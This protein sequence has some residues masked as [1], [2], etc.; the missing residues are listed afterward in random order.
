MKIIAARELGIR[1][2][3]SNCKMAGYKSEEFRA[4]VFEN[5]MVLP[6]IEMPPNLLFDFGNMRL[7]GSTGLGALMEISIIT[8]LVKGQIGV[9]DIESHIE[10]VFVV[11]HLSSQFAH[12][13][14]ENEA[15]L[16]L[17]E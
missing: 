10:N 9:I 3:G 2:F 17:R 1:I 12:F 7:M 11:S 5:V 15:I 6:Q 4:A 16:V 13:D 14:T 8:K